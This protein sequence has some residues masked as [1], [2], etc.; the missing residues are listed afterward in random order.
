MVN[1]RLKEISILNLFEQIQEN[2]ISG[3]A[4]SAQLSIFRDRVSRGRVYRGWGQFARGRGPGI[5]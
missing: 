1:I 5:M 2:I 3:S 4:F